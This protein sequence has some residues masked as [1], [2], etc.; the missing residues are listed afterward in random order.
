[1]TANR[2]TRNGG[3]AILEG[4][5]RITLPKRVGGDVL[6][7]LESGIEISKA[8]KG[9][10]ASAALQ[11][12]PAV[13]A[14]CEHAHRLAAHVALGAG[15]TT[16]LSSLAALET[17][18]E[19]VMR[20]TMDW[21][22]L[23]G[24]GPHPAG[25]RAAMQLSR[26]LARDAVSV[27]EA[28]D[29]VDE[30]LALYVFG[31]APEQWAADNLR[32]WA[33]RGQ[34]PPA[35]VIAF[36]YER[37]WFDA[38][39]MRSDDDATVFARRSDDPKLTGLGAGLGA[40]MAARLVELARMPEKLRSGAGALQ[41]DGAVAAARGPLR[42]HASLNGDVIESYRIDTPTDANF[43]PDGLAARML[44]SLTEPDAEARM[45]QARLVVGAVDPC[46]RCEMEYADA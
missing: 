27:E 40:R 2:P 39:A 6:V 29:R 20:M 32:D 37:G 33:L 31:G 45:L 46:V 18:R 4:V 7:R 42:H 16:K 15:V 41:S 14:V 10:P 38:A 34:T 1:M 22:A 12:I 24:E 3:S 25:A 21:P 19:H 5:L 11:V 8:L 13:F 23:I 35:R 43:T 30:L 28:A 17:L 26:D 9:K 44:A 36:L